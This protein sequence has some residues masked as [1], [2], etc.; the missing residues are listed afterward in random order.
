MASW[1]LAGKEPQ[2]Q[3]FPTTRVG[4]ATLDHRWL[5]VWGA[6]RK[7]MKRKVVYEKTTNKSTVYDKITPGYLPFR[8]VFF[9]GKHRQV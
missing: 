1:P 3:G 4:L 2:N 7:R 6:Q 5:C 9:S 8:D